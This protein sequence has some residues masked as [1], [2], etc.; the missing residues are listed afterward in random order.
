MSPFMLPL[1]P[2]TQPA[3]ITIREA[4]PPSLPP[5]PQQSLSLSSD[6]IIEKQAYVNNL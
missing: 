5:S 4:T 2:I 1:F 3:G 6:E